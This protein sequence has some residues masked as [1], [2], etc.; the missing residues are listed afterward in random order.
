MD[1]RRAIAVVGIGVLSAGAVMMAPIAAGA[2]TRP[3]ASFSGVTCALSGGGGEVDFTYEWSKSATKP[4]RYQVTV[5]NGSSFTSFTVTAGSTSPDLKL[6]NTFT[7]TP[8]KAW[9]K[10][11][12]SSGSII[13]VSSIA[14]CTA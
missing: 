10:A 6:D 3:A 13:A 11:I 5:A 14:N 1:I 9:V 12:R 2:V 4:A 8:T 7:G